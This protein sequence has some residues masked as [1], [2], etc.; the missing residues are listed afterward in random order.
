MIPSLSGKNIFKWHSASKPKAE[1]DM[2]QFFL[3]RE[4]FMP[5]VDENLLIYEK[6]GNLISYSKGLLIKFPKSEKFDL[7]KDIKET[8][9]HGFRNTISAW[10]SR[11]NM[12]RLKHLDAIDVDVLVLK[13][14]VKLAYE[15][16]YISEKN[17]MTWDSKI[18]EIG[19]LTGG[20]I[21]SCQRE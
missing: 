5:K 3:K 14:F 11:N 9:Y 18:A 6:F 8:L 4:L 12:D 17:F 7:C 10:K 1:C 13:N 2:P 19:R 15:Y 16:K 20:W 21:K